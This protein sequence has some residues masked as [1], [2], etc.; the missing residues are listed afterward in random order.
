MVQISL[1]IFSNSLVFIVFSRM[2]YL[3]VVQNRLLFCPINHLFLATI[4]T[5]K[6]Y[7]MFLKKICEWVL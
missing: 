1:T 3:R 7:K 5:S 4:S 2:V 6:S